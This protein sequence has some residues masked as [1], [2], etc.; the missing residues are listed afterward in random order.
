MKKK[1]QNLTK[2]V[3]KII[4]HSRDGNHGKEWFYKSCW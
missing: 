3:A 2:L 1:I 4:Q